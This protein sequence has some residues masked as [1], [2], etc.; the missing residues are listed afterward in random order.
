[1]REHEAYIS[2]KAHY[3]F[4]DES[5]HPIHAHI[6]L[7]RILKK[8]VFDEWGLVHW[9]SVSPK[10]MTDKIYL[11]LK[12]HGSPLHFRELTAK[13]NQAGFGGRPAYAP[14]VHNELI[15]DKR[16]VLV[17]RGI[18]ALTEWGYAPGVVGDVA[19]AILKKAGKALA[20]EEIVEEVLKQRLV[21]RGTIY[22]A[23][24]NQNRFRRD[25]EGNYHLTQ[26]VIPRSP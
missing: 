10:R 3:G 9:P 19:A 23:L 12:K 14:T 13:I 1:L 4:S 6:R 26:S 24:S 18:Y 2:H 11:L 17:G 15:L 20:R 16:Y 7:S 8:N 25:E 22:L 21:K 5:P